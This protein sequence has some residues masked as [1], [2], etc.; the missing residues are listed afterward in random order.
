MSVSF[1]PK[2]IKYALDNYAVEY[3]SSSNTGSYYYR[4]SVYKN[5]GL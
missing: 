5:L 3:A 2:I 4:P 1:Q